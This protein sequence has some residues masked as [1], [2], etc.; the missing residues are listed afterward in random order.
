MNNQNLVEDQFV[1]LQ[2][3]AYVKHFMQKRTVKLLFIVSLALVITNALFMNSFKDFLPMLMEFAQAVEGSGITAEDSS[4]INQFINLSMNTS[5]ITTIV[6]K[7]ILPI[8]LLYIIIR[9]KSEN[10][11]VIPSGTVKFLYV[12]SFIQSIVV[13]LSSIFSLALQILSIFAESDIIS[14]ILSAVFVGVAL[15]F[16]CLY[17]ILQTKFLKALKH[18]STGYSLIYGSSKGFGI[19]SV[20][21]CIIF[22]LLSA[23]SI[24]LS[25]VFYSLLSSN[26]FDTNNSL[27]LFIALGGG[28]LFNSL[29]PSIIIFIIISMLTALYFAVLASLAFSYKEM[30]QIAIRES[31][32]SPSRVSANTN[33]AFRTYGGS[34]SY[35]NYNYSSSNAGSQQSYSHTAMNLEKNTPVN[36]PVNNPINTTPD[37]NNDPILQSPINDSYNP[38]NN[39]PQQYEEPFGNGS[40]TPTQP[41]VNN[42]INDDSFATNGS[43]GNGSFNFNNE[44]S[45]NNY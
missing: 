5:M 32:L 34:N 21:Y 14:A 30:V 10:P 24:I 36:N 7:L 11:T 25:V 43:F 35:T 2:N 41:V 40:F 45:Y 23:V 26:S 1:Q 18:S 27:Q 33:S 38:Y 3:I 20:I 4:S 12:I 28:E 29:K 31:F 19:I 8:S 15:F 39:A 44:D 17:Y 22:G 42:N 37:F 9:S 16:S 13:I 6:L